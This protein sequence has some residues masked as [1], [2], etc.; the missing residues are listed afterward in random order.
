MI[1]S[2][3]SLH[4]CLCYNFT[5]FLFFAVYTIFVLIFFCFPLTK[6]RS[7][8]PLCIKAFGFGG[9]QGIR[10]LEAVFAAYT[11]SSRAPSTNSDNSPF[12]TC[13]GHRH[14]HIISNCPAK[15][16]SFF[17]KYVLKPCIYS[18]KIALLMY[19][20]QAASVSTDAA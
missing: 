15:I 12:K 6:N 11:I 13:L 10:T 9:E 2:F 5:R 14:L 7:R 8:K 18:A 19:N 3:R 20:N 17:K 1:V 16:K 4:D